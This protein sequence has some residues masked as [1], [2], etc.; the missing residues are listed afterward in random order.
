MTR[1][2]KQKK[3]S[4]STREEAKLILDNV[5]NRYGIEPSRPEGTQR[6]IMPLA[7][8]RVE[9]EEPLSNPTTSAPLSD[10][11]PFETVGQSEIGPPLNLGW[12]SYLSDPPACPH[13][14]PSNKRAL[15]FA[16]NEIFADKPEGELAPAEYHDFHFLVRILECASA[17]HCQVTAESAA[18]ARDR[19]GRIPNLIDWREISVRE[20]A[21]IIKSE[22]EAEKF[23]GRS[24]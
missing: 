11:R 9:A 2:S 18:A 7:A 10:R 13:I 14:F 6:K 5:L 17:L 21:E 23:D 15:W 4:K 24:V 3:P 8:S 20:L 19:I 22:R 12:R 1:N 16:G